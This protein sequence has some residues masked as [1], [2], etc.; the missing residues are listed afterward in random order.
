MP[1]SRGPSRFEMTR[2][3]AAI[4]MAPDSSE[5]TTATASVRSVMP[6]AARWR[7]P[8]KPSMRSDSGSVALA[9]MMRSSR[10]IAAPSWS[11]EF[12]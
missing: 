11:A 3:L 10:R 8:W 9:A 5:T 1:R 2:P 6:S 12:G 4:E 7:V